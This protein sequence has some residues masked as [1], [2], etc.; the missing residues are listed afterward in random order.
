MPTFS[1]LS[2][3]SRKDADRWRKGMKEKLSYSETKWVKKVEPTMAEVEGFFGTNDDWLF[4]AGHFGGVQSEWGSWPYS[5]DRRLYNDPDDDVTTPPT[6]EILFRSDHALVRRKS[7]GSWEEKKLRKGT[8]LKQSCKVILWG[9]C[10]VC[11][12]QAQL[13]VIRALFGQPLVI[14]WLGITGWKIV[15]I[16]LG[17]HGGNPDPGTWNT[18]NFWNELGSGHEDPVKIRNA[19]LKVAKSIPWGGDVLE[20]FCVIDPDGTRHKATDEPLVS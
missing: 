13:N 5:G 15:D 6:H 8:E 12:N 9:G 19:W 16:M 10:D 7:G 18:P 20:R 11:S 1:S 14:G 3:G 2:L 4:M 17:G